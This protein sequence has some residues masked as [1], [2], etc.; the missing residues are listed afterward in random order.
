MNRSHYIVHLAATIY[1]SSRSN[2]NIRCSPNSTKWISCHTH[3]R[4]NKVIRHLPNNH[5]HFAPNLKFKLFQANEP[6]S[7]QRKQRSDRENEIEG[8]REREREKRIQNEICGDTQYG[9]TMNEVSM[10]EPGEKKEG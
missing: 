2:G 5:L 4:R 3:F 1:R 8:K 9:A 10:N 6:P 7:W